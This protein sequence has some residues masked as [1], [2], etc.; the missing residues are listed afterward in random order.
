MSLTL[1]RLALLVCC[2]LLAAGGQEAFAQD[3]TVYLCS[4]RDYLPEWY[5]TPGC[6]CDQVLNTP[7]VPPPVCPGSTQQ[8]SAP[9]APVSWPLGVLARA[10]A[11]H[12]VTLTWQPWVCSP[13]WVLRI[14]AAPVWPVTG[15]YGSL[16]GYA[17]YY[18]PLAVLATTD[19]AGCCTS[20]HTFTDPAAVFPPPSYGPFIPAEQYRVC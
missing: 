19:A 10:T 5:Y 16:V 4:Q 20:Q 17:V 7:A 3:C 9:G 6:D 1:S 11:P 15:Y 14:D 12:T 8:P 18:T 2:G 13:D